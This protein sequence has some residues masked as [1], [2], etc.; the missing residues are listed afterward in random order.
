MMV[1]LA[2]GATTFGVTFGSFMPGFEAFKTTLKFSKTFGSGFTIGGSQ[3]F[4]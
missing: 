3:A 2:L 1:A 4:I